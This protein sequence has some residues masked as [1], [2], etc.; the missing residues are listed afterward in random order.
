M[1]RALLIVTAWIVGGEFTAHADLK[2]AE[3]L[4]PVQKQQIA[5]AMKIL[6]E[7]G[8][9]VQEEKSLQFD[10]DILSVLEAEGRIEYINERESSI[11]VGPTR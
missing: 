1:K 8:T 9:V 5:W 6:G 10:Q 4:T 3:Q 7:T 11:C 2:Q